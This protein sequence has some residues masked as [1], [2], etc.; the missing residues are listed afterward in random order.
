L[1]GWQRQQADVGV[2]KVRR[3]PEAIGAIRIEVTGLTLS[4]P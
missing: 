3:M 4:I 1:T 2:E